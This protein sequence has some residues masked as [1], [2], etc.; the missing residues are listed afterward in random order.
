[1]TRS[2]MML[3]ALIGQMTGEQAWIGEATWTVGTAVVS[4]GDQ[5][6]A[7]QA[8]SGILDGDVLRMQ[9]G[10]GAGVD[11]RRQRQVMFAPTTEVVI[12]TQ[13]PAASVNI[14][15]GEVRG[16]S[17]GA[18]ELHTPQAKVSLNSGIVRAKVGPTGTA[19]WCES[20]K[21]TIVYD[22]A[23]R[24]VSDVR[25]VAARLAQETLVLGA[26]EAV[27]IP[28]SGG[29]AQSIDP[30][31]EAW[32]N[33]QSL[34]LRGAAAASRSNKGQYIAG[35]ANS[36][37]SQYQQQM[38][39]N[40]QQQAQQQATTQ[41]AEP[42]QDTETTSQTDIAVALGPSLQLSALGSGAGVT[43]SGGSG[44]DAGQFSVG[45]SLGLIGSFETSVVNNGVITGTEQLNQFDTF[46]DYIHIVTAE[47]VF[48]INNSDAKPTDLSSAYFSVATDPTNFRPTY[49]HIT[50][51]SSPGI[52]R[53]DAKPIAVPGTNLHVVS[54][55]NLANVPDGVAN[56]DPALGPSV[57][58]PGFDPNGA[59]LGQE[60]GGVAGSLGGD[61]PGVVPNGGSANDLPRFNP[62]FGLVNIGSGETD[63]GSIN[64]KLTYLFGAFRFSRNDD[65]GIEVATRA[66]DQDRQFEDFFGGFGV[67]PNDDVDFAR[68]ETDSAFNRFFPFR[69]NRTP[70]AI[71]DLDAAH[72]SA[73]TVMAGEALQTYAR[74]TG[75][76]RFVID[77]QLIDITGYRPQ[78]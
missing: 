22:V 19:V 47:N 57:L 48:T 64:Q 18:L 10:A 12:R 68:V 25:R 59:L 23:D 66:S 50:P 71:R 62:D 65:G 17:A 39:N 35:S 77:G 63:G 33:F 54:W 53:A 15:Y 58:D 32:A 45:Q 1:M 31:S 5:N 6:Y 26:G 29:G 46:D 4:R 55:G 72:R 75:Q 69:Y 56:Q 9:A 20:G 28:A 41:P 27:L 40:Q 36:D 8:A 37:R 76:T 60:L 2:I 49:D 51:G 11:L 61:P 74:R 42:N 43:G 67:D 30:I 13:G 3:A 78:P 7:L 14:A 44:S 73:L 70:T 16:L 52:G 24:A 21:A 34:Q 38:A